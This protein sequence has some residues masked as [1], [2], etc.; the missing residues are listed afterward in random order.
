MVV[1]DL[2]AV[3]VNEGPAVTELCASLREAHPH[4]ELISG[5]GAR[6][7]SDI[8]S[9]GMAGCDS[10]LVASAL[11]DGRLSPEEVRRRSGSRLSL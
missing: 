4:L 8:E 1:L 11:H 3:G 5:G 7:L 10:V 6:G 2:A 9:L